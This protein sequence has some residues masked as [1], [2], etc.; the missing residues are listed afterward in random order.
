MYM[1][2]TI[3]LRRENKEEENWGGVFCSQAHIILCSLIGRK[4]E[5]EA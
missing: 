5:E 2:S 3:W 1:F 4:M